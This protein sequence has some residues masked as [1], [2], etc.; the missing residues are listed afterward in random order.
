M[1]LVKLLVIVLLILAAAIV[2]GSYLYLR[3]TL[4]EYDGQ[5]TASGL[6]APVDVIRDSCG[7]PHIFAQS[8]EDAYFALGY[9]MAQDRLVQME[10]M[11]LMARGRLSE[12]M[13]PATVEV[14]K[15]HRLILSAYDLEESFKSS[16]SPAR[17]VATA[18]VRGIN[19][20]IRDPRS[21]IAPEFVASGHQ[22]QLFTIEDVA[23]VKPLFVWM[24]SASFRSELL[25]AAVI[26]KVGPEMANELFIDHNEGYPTTIPEGESLYPG[27][28]EA[29]IPAAIQ[30]T[31]TG[32]I[33]KQENATTLLS[34][35]T[36]IE[37]TLD[38]LGLLQPGVACNSLVI[39]GEKTASGK[40]IL[41]QDY[42]LM[43]TIPSFLYEAHL[44]T[45]T[46]TVTGYIF[47]GQPYV[48]GGQ[49]EHVSWVFTNGGGDEID[50]YME[51]LHPDD[52]NKYLHKN[53]Y[54][55]MEV[56]KEIIK[57]K[58]G[59]DVEMTVRLTRHGPVIDELVKDYLKPGEGDT[60]Y[61]IRMAAADSYTENEALYRMNTAKSAD[62]FLDGA[63]LY[64]CPGQHWIYA[65]DNGEIGYFYGAGIPIRKGF[66]GTV[67]VPGWTGEH[68]WQGYV[69]TAMQ[70]QVRNPRM[71]F[72]NTSNAKPAPDSY[73]YHFGH[74]HASEDRLV[75]VREIISDTIAKNGKFSAGD[76]DKVFKDSYLLMA[77]EWVPLI[78]P[79]MEGTTLN[80]NE[81]KALDELSKW[82]YF[83][84]KDSG[85]A[86]IHQATFLR[87]I[88]DT[89]LKHL[90]KELYDELLGAGNVIKGL[91]CMMTDEESP[92]FDN[93]GTPE[94]EGRSELLARSFK[95]AVAY[96]EQQMGADVD[97]WALGD[98]LT[99]TLRHP[100]SKKLTFMAPLVNVGP[101][102]M[103]GGFVA[104]FA[105]Y[106][107]LA[108]PFDVVAGTQARFVV[109]F[110]DRE[111]CR[112][113]NMPGISGNF[114]SRHYDD[115]VRMW[116]KFKSRPLM[117]YREEA[118][119]DARH[120]LK[121]IPE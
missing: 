80:P 72:I 44:S 85:A 2:L 102:K 61:S 93:P 77:R 46:F 42:H 67:P 49:N 82:D 11:R 63:A 74:N 58:G 16:S 104:P 106:Y 103:S 119:K 5:L 6:N 62:E 108:K 14:D 92:W 60:V 109:D 65:D 57:V 59:E 54:E 69:P 115:Q 120:V 3:A 26:Q 9:C 110:A 71:G 50:F 53:S 117:L 17:M 45:P 51:K 30:A 40:P 100:L 23:L 76:V 18:F 84:D 121:M 91:R 27:F 66:D 4:P 101:L 64:K 10:I 34:A 68:E 78:I 48:F 41:A 24:M 13:G 88:E 98:C 28:K 31:A 97:A 33:E 89:F 56:R 7:V 111:N 86:L 25:K 70:P 114:I 90:G 36:D 39:S 8:E 113:V 38:S 35:L 1:R 15:L 107:D 52:P 22:P 83:S 87:V 32:S 55:D 112:I 43:H 37:N 47:V 99:L 105:I 21:S 12:M 20:Y 73:P 118:E 116:Y 75:R 19:A 94:A 81:Q 79:A 29:A 96:L 95:E